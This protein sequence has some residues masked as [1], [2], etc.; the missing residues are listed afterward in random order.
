M[1]LG[2]N[3]IGNRGIRALSENLWAIPNLQK[4]CFVK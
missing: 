2:N 3:K 4:L 1:H